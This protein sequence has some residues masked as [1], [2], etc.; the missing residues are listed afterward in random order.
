M[1]ILGAHV[2]ISGG[3]E[4]SVERGVLLGCESI[5]IFSKNQRQWKSPPLSEKSIKCFIEKV[6]ASSIREV[7]IHDSYLI[8][9]ASPD[10]ASLKKSREAFYDE[11]VRA[12][13][14]KIRYL[15]FH[16][17]SHMKTSESEG[18]RRIVESL[19]WVL[20]KQPTGQVLLL[21]ENTAGQGDHL[22]YRFEQLAEMLQGIENRKRMGICFD[23]AHAFGA[24]YDI[25]TQETYKETFH[26][27]EKIIGMENLKAFHL[28]DSKVEF[29]SRV[30]RHDH[31]GEGKIGLE[32]FR[33]LVNDN[34]FK[35]VPMILETPGD[36]D[37]YVKNL[38]TL[39]SLIK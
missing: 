37:R 9:L 12:D 6:I 4:K 7:V 1:G 28:N 26:Q 24:G 10:S 15:V 5:Q 35:E 29:G 19:N 25:R 36:E 34:R 22:G 17:G 23:T 14:L 11:M 16:P 13:Q 32:G 31:I 2:S 38:E 39:R 20:S 3:V 30:D 33:F 21:I 27:F 8:N 18:I